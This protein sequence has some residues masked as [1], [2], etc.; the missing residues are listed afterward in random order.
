MSG[1][2]VGAAFE[3]GKQ[4]ISGEKVDVK[5]GLEFVKGAAKGAVAGTGIGLIASAGAN[6]GIDAFGNVLEQ[7]VVEGKSFNQVNLVETAVW[8]AGETL[9]L[10]SLGKGFDFVK[11]KVGINTTSIKLTQGK[12]NSGT[13]FRLMNI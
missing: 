13:G 3:A 9:V 12:S 1:G 8:S 5:I 4:V 10:G 6:T 2:V 11:N 7:T